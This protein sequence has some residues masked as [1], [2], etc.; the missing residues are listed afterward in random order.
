MKPGIAVETFREEEEGEEEQGGRGQGGGGG[1]GGVSHR[2]H[3]GASPGFFFWFPAETLLIR[4]AA[5]RA[6]HALCKELRR[7]IIVPVCDSFYVCVEV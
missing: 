2:I 5:P 3:R 1:G 4:P 6:Y 7:V